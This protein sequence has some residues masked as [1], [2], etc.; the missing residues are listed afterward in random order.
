MKELRPTCNPNGIYSV[1]QTCAER[2]T[3][4]KSVVISD[5]LTPLMFAALNTPDN[6]SLI[7]GTL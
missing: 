7:A 5:R 6:Q 4:T 3:N 1:K 2:C